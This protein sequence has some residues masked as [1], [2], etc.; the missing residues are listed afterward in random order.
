M[1]RIEQNLYVVG[2]QSYNR[3]IAENRYNTIS[4]RLSVRLFDVLFLFP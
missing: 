3:V 2:L 4:V 1:A